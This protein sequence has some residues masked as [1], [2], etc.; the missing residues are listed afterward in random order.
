MATWPVGLGAA[1]RERVM[2]GRRP[3]AGRQVPQLEMAEEAST[4][5][6]ISD[7]RKGPLKIEIHGSAYA[8]EHY[9]NMEVKR[10]I[11]L[12][13]PKYPEEEIHLIPTII[14]KYYSNIVIPIRIT[15]CVL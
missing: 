6:E 9:G 12:V 1:I 11:N 13:L 4:P 7:R 8:V 10:Q 5:V 2:K 15:N 3:K 14:N